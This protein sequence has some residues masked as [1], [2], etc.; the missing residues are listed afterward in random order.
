MPKI[1]LHRASIGKHR[2]QSLETLNEK[3]SYSDN[4][5]TSLQ[6]NLGNQ[7]V[8]QMLTSSDKESIGLPINMQPSHWFG[9]SI[10]E[11][12]GKTNVKHADLKEDVKHADE[13]ELHRG[14]NYNDTSF[15]INP[16]EANRDDKSA[17]PLFHADLFSEK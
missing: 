1:G 9:L 2:R 11:D 5:I 14:K 13:K 8:G 15:T 3:G 12:S 16:V 10:S 7:A 6:K 4:D 17:P